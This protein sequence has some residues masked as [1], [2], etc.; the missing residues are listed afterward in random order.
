MTTFDGLV[1]D[2]Y[3]N[4]QGFGLSQPRAAFLT[5]DITN[6][7]LQIAVGNA[8]DFEQGIAEI[9]TELVFI[10]SV[11]YPSKILTIAPDGRGWYGSTA[12]AHLTNA[13]ITMAPTWPKVQIA[14]AVNDAISATYPD[15]FAIGSASFTFDISVTTYALPAT[16]Q[17]VLRVTSDTFSASQEQVQFTRYSF[18]PQAPTAIFP[19]GKS[20]TVENC[21]YP[22]RSITVVFET[23]PVEITFGDAFTLSGLAETAKKA[24]KYAA[25]SALTAGMDLA[26]LPV[27]TAT[28]DEYDPS[29][30]AIGVAGRVSAQLYQRYLIELAVERKRLR[31]LAPI[32]IAV[33][34]R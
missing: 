31:A 13:R 19:T 29:R 30:N 25:L 14:E 1:N 18:N 33:R 12:A 3:Q 9:G 23:A 20:I 2:C 6:S 11:D 28:A 26:R 8:D 27:D 10:D 7:A 34:T 17:R 24:V 5:A 32:P 15:L 4:L 22:G 16:A 21:G